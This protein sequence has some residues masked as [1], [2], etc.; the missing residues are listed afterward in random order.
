L[1]ANAQ[2]VKATAAKLPYIAWGNLVVS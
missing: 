1:V 2:Q